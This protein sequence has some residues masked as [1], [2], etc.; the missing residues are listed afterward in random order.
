MNFPRKSSV[1]LTSFNWTERI[2][3]IVENSYGKTIEFDKLKKE[4]NYSSIE[5]I[6]AFD[7]TIDYQAI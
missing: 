6:N 7:S 5:F 4:V 3:G 2:R 1:W